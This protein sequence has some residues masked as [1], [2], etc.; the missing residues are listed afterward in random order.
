MAQ[1]GQEFEGNL[2]MNITTVSLFRSLRGILGMALL[3]L[4]DC[5]VGSSKD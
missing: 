1:V 3:K 5:G 2:S 4:R